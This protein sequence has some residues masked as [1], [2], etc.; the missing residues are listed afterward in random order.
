M[1]GDKVY[2]QNQRLPGALAKSWD[3]S[4][5]VIDSRNAHIDTYLVKYDGSGQTTIRNRQYLRKYKCIDEGEDIQTPQQ[6]E[7][8]GPSTDF[9]CDAADRNIPTPVQSDIIPLRKERK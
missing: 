4:G 3:K 7:V 5:I 9:I 1:D 6:G 2:I 8:D